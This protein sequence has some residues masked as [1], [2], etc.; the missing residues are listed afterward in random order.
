MKSFFKKVEPE[1]VLYKVKYK[2]ISEEEIRNNINSYDFGTRLMFA[3]KGKCLDILIKDEDWFVRQEV[4]YQ[5]YGLDILINDENYVVR[6]Q[7][8][9]QGYGLDILINDENWFVKKLV[10]KILKIR[11]L[12]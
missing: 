2:L 6:K 3:R 9:K 1:N 11:G 5:G 10:E 4:A 8:A 7:V 12:L